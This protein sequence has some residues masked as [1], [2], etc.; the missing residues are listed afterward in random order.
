[1]ELREHCQQ[2]FEAAVTAVQPGQLIP[3]FLELKGNNLRIGK[4]LIPLTATTKIFVIGAGKASATMAQAVEKIAGKRIAKGF[5]ATKYDHAQ[6]LE[7]IEC[8]EASHP[9]PDQNGVIAVERTI[10]VVQEARQQDI[11]ICLLSGGASAL[12]ADLPAGI[13]L[14]A[15][16]QTSSLLLQCGAD[17]AEMNT[18]RKHLS[19]IKGGQLLSYAPRS[20]W[21][22]LIISDVPGDMLT[23]IGSG[24]TV[25]DTS[26]FEDVKKIIEKY[27][28][29][30]QLPSPVLHHI[31]KGIKGA[32]PETIKPGN[33]VLK[34]CSNFLIGSNLIALA[35]AK[36][37]AQKLGYHTNVLESCLQGDT[38]DA[39]RNL[40]A[41]YSSYRGNRPACFLTGGETTLQV[42]GKGKGGRNQHMVL[43]VLHE[44]M[45]H[46]IPGFC[47]L[48]AGSDGTD[49][50]T[51]AAGAFADQLTLARMKEKGL[52]LAN[53]L[54]QQDSY[55]FFKEAAAL[56]KTGSTGTNVMDLSVAIIE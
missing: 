34:N 47:F 9:V 27:K 28:L 15:L 19:R 44:M 53:Y 16:Q 36:N 20:G 48:A 25:D 56:F 35:A 22:S 21:F 42:T 37:E 31:E 18:V 13:S 17:I 46:E 29:A 33:A 4:E 24:P 32:I 54:Q 14:E 50:P 49:G 38:T 30:D 23:V 39:A 1:M 51:D 45:T 55:H 2:I 6:P 10:A 8:L 40:F 52:L 41:I 43:Q 5:I 3:E 11:I 7:H 26:S 12:W